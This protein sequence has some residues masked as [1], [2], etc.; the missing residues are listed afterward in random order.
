MFAVFIVLLTYVKPID[1]VE[2]HLPAHREFLHRHY[3]TGAFLLSGPKE[4]RTG[5]V[6][7]VNLDS[8]EAMQTILA[9][10][11]FHRHGVAEYTIIELT[12]TMAA[13]PLQW[14]L[15]STASVAP[16][17]KMEMGEM[18]P[19]LTTAPSVA[20]VLEELE[21]REPIFHRPE[22]GTTR[23]A[24]EAMTDVN[25]WEVGASGR[26]YSRQYVIDA[27]VERHSKPHEDVWETSGFHCLQL[28]SDTYLLTYTLVQDRV[29]ATRRS[30]VWQKHD[31]AW[32]IM[33]HQGTVVEET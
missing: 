14:L 7:L 6:I 26:R 33:Y 25:F 27:L 8:H 20:D 24:F 4:P 10:D 2:S 29:R 19:T 32:K 30:T 5:G 1:L 15:G 16:L 21:R 17:E 23:H 31:G 11:P 3:G 9:E 13:P 12:A 22:F 28:S 18:E